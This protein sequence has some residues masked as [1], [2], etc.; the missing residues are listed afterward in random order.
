MSK[1]ELI[2]PARSEHKFFRIRAVP[3]D[4]DNNLG[5]LID[6]AKGKMALHFIWNGEDGF[7]VLTE[8]E[9]G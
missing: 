9:D 5:L 6:T 8:F 2:L 4:M 3:L 1:C 7:R